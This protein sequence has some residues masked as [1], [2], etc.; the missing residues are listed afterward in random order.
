MMYYINRIE[1]LMLMVILMLC[2][3][4]LWGIIINVEQNKSLHDAFVTSV[5]ERRVS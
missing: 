3:T 1:R 2:C 5:E 4:P